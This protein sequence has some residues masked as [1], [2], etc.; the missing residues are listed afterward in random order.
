MPISFRLQ[1]IEAAPSLAQRRITEDLE[2]Q[3]NIK[4]VVL[5]HYVTLVEV[6]KHY[7]SVGSAMSTGEIDI[8]EASDKELL[9]KKII[10]PHIVIEGRKFVR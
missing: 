10:S 7:A 8:M 4:D 1:T 6:F 5:S 9:Y 2:E 3:S